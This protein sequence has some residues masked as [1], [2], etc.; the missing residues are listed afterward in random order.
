MLA[1]LLLPHF[2]NLVNKELSLVYLIDSQLI[3]IYLSLLTF[4][5]FLAG[6]YPA[7]I[8]SGYNPV[9]TLY[10]KF[11]LSGKNYLQKT[12]ILFQFSLATF[13]VIAT[14]IVYM[15]FDFLTSKDLGYKPDYV[16]KVNKR[17]LTHQEA[18]IFSEALSKNAN[19]ISLSPQH[20]GKENG[21]INTDSVFHFTYE[22]VNEN[23]IDLFKIILNH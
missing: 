4:T 10:A 18:K 12:L 20:N 15:Q 23:F 8:L 16:V 2:N 1:Q 22:A 7:I 21:K 17:R 6:F 5:G 9:Q 3:I 11:K 19:I 14:A 13:M